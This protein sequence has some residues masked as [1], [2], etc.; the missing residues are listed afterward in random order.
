LQKKDI[1]KISDFKY[2]PYCSYDDD[3]LMFLLYEGRYKFVLLD[4]MKVVHVSHPVNKN[5]ETNFIY[6]FSELV[7]RNF[8]C[9]NIIL[10]LL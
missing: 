10:P 7:K 6:Y 1:K 3:Y 5:K 9:F 4:E 8:Y 2:F